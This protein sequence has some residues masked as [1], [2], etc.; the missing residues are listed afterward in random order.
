MRPSGMT[1]A[2]REA[3]AHRPVAERGAFAQASALGTHMVTIAAGASSAS[4]TV[5]T[6]DDAVDEPDGSVVATVGS[7]AGYMIGTARHAS[8][9]V[10]EPENGRLWRSAGTAGG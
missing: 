3:G 2:R 7:R 6:E 9:A 8:V 4:F 1:C 10:R 5:A